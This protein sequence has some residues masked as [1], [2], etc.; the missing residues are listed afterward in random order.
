M[1]LGTYLVL[2]RLDK[3][4]QNASSG[5][6][7]FPQ[8]AKLGGK[9]LVSS[10]YSNAIFSGAKHVD[11]IIAA[12]PLGPAG[13]ALYRGAK[14][15]HN[16]AFNLGQAL[17]LV[18]HLRIHAWFSESTKRLSV[19][20][21]FALG[22][23]GIAFLG[24]TTFCAYKIRL[25][26]TASLGTPSIQW[27]FLLL[28]FTGAGLVFAC[29]ITSLVVFSIRKR[30]FV[31][32]STMEIAGSL[33]LLSGLCVAFGVVGAAQSVAVSCG[34]VLVSSLMVVRRSFRVD[35]VR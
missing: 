6:A 10:W 24:L 1:L 25:F 28:I 35:T 33:S 23:A 18:L 22:A 4:N 13:A 7:A 3:A 27:L 2:R 14:S 5:L 32:L 15:V 34:C 19:L 17:S 11:V 29:R 12:M 16:I 21:A 9:E 31:I 26:P 30:S 20:P 8:L